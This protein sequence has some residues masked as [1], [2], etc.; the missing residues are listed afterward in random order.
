[1]NRSNFTKKNVFNDKTYRVTYK[2][3][4]LELKTIPKTKSL[5][6]S[7]FKS[8]KDIK[9]LK[10]IKCGKRF[11]GKKFA[12][13]T[14]DKPILWKSRKLHKGGYFKGKYKPKEK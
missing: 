2:N 7:V 12:K 14:L 13:S 10:K 9:L 6:R 8:K 11:K 1:M 3:H 4:A 5:D